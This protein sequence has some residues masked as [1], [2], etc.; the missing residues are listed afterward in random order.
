M[1]KDIFQTLKLAA[2]DCKLAFNEQTS[3]RIRGKK[4]RPHK[5]IFK[6]YISIT[7]I[8]ITRYLP[9]PQNLKHTL[10]ACTQRNN[11]PAELIA[12]VEDQWG[13]YLSSI[14]RSKLQFFPCKKTGWRWWWLQQ[15]KLQFMPVLQPTKKG[16]GERKESTTSERFSCNEMLEDVLE[17]N[18]N[19]S[20]SSAKIFSAAVK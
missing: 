17:A 18:S 6:G 3:S 8:H 4:S 11:L 5:T 16:R 19:L 9:K 13:P 7:G 15:P 12:L 14:V 10:Q 1:Q 20:V 2:I